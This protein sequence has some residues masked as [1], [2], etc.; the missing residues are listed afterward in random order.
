VFKSM[1]HISVILFEMKKYIEM[2]AQYKQLLEFIPNVTRNEGAEAIDQVLAALADCSDFKLQEQV[3]DVTSHALARMPESERMLFDVRMKLCKVYANR[4]AWAEANVVLQSLHKSCQTSDGMD[5]KKSKGSELLEIYAL[6]L[7]MSAATGD[8]VKLKELFEKTKD[9]IVAVKD[10]RS[11]S[12]I[13]ECWGQMFGDDG[14]WQKA[15]AEFFSAFIHFDEIGNAEKAKQCLKY[16]V[17]ANMLSGSDAN[18]FDAREAKVYQNDKDIESVGQLRTA[19]EKCDV[20]AFNKALDEIN[21]A[22]DPFIQKHLDS[23]ISDFQSRSIISLIKSYRRIKI[24]HLAQQLRVDVA[25][26]E[27]IL[28]H[29][30]LDGSIVGRIDQVRGLLDLTQRSGGGAKKYHALDVWAGTLSTLTSNLPQPHA[31]N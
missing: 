26:I 15:K 3:Y 9:L 28:V 10:P 1:V 11:Q 8:Q 17:I 19:Y 31:F 6:E 16:F 27:E 30:I 14:Q 4:G 7:R 25:R 21:M 22:K 20:N 2:I 5:D 13:K 12:V 24:Q 29:L 23:M 18:P